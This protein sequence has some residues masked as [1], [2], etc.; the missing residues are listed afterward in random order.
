MAALWTPRSTSDGLHGRQRRLLA[1]A[2][3]FHHLLCLT[4]DLVCQ[5]KFSRYESHTSLKM[6]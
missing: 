1:E 4:E 3:L 2:S 6:V 5:T